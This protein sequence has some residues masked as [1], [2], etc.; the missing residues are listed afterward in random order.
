MANRVK[1]AAR[2]PAGAIASPQ[3]RAPASP[4]E[5]GTYRARGKVQSSAPWDAAKASQPRQRPVRSARSSSQPPASV[6][7]TTKL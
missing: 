6:A 1:S 2:A 5:S 4:K 7:S 3:A